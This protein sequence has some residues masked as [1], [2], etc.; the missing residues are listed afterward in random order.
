MTGRRRKL[1]RCEGSIGSRMQKRL[2]MKI[3][4]LSVVSHSSSQAKAFGR[5]WSR[6]PAHRSEFCRLVSP[7]RCQRIRCKN[8]TDTLRSTSARKV[9]S[10]KCPCPPVV[11]RTIPLSFL[12]V[13]GTSQR[14]YFSRGASGRSGFRKRVYRFDPARVRSLRCL[15]SLPSEDFRSASTILRCR[16]AVVPPI[17]TVYSWHTSPASAR[18]AR[19]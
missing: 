13:C 16:C 7:M 12:T 11:S 10:R 5:L 9:T 19:G 2:Q 8:R 18:T 1:R 17:S 6:R 3:S 14:E 4:W 15:K